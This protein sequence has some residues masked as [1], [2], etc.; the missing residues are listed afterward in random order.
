[1]ALKAKKQLLLNRTAAYIG[2][3]KVGLDIETISYK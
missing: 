2:L 1:V 3:K